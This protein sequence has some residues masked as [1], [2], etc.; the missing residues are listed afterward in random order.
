MRTP[1]S[2]QE[3]TRG[4]RKP[5]SAITCDRKSLE[6]RKKAHEGKAQAAAGKKG[7]GRGETAL[8]SQGKEKVFTKDSRKRKSSRTSERTFS[9]GKKENHSPWIRNHTGFHPGI[10]G[11]RETQAKTFGEKERSSRKSRVSFTKGLPGGKDGKESRHTIKEKR[12]IKLLLAGR[13]GRGL[14]GM[15]QDGIRKVAR[16]K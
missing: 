9:F 3:N 2:D 6:K 15:A 14:K 13:E 8:L 1:R 5:T 16:Q 12:F 4:R 7:K 11:T 10:E